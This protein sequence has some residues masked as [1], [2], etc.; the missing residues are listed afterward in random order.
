MKRELPRGVYEK[1]GAYYR[2]AQNK[3]T[4]LSAVRDGLPAMYR[5]LAAATERGGGIRTMGDLVDTW[6]KEV[7]ITRK[8]K[9]QAND[10]YQC[11]HIKRSLK[12]FAPDQVRAPD[13]AECLAYFKAMPRS[14]NAHR[15]MLRELMRFAEEKGL[16]ESGT[17]PVNAIKTMSTKARTRYVTDSEL[18]RIKVGA[19]YF[20]TKKK[21]ARKDR[22]KTDSGYMLCALID[23]AYLTGQRIGDLLALKWDDIGRSGIEFEPT[24][25]EDS[26]GAR[27]LIQATPKLDAVVARLRKL[28]AER[29]SLSPY[30]FTTTGNT[31]YTYSGAQSAWKRAMRRAKVKGCTFHDLRA[32]AI[33]DVDESRGRRDANRMGAHT[34]ENQTAAYVRHKTAR[35]TSA[36]R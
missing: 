20:N 12:E 5:A 24:K 4:R 6:L 22:K 2:V 15:S 16:R 23:M 35:K 10:S 3:W 8:R 26:S 31:P 17:N 14:Y 36:T 27:V 34:T 1:H 29:K 28:K 18:R 30:V 11:Q 33:T 19:V 13:V 9:T 25:L 7:S 32:K 21:T